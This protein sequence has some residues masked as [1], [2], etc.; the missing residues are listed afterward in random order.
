[1][2]NVVGLEK[3]GGY[4]GKYMKNRSELERYYNEILTRFIKLFVMP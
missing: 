3:N 2:N 1:M 4:V